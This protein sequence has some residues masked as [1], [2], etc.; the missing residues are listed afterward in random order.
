[1]LRLEVLGLVFTEINDDRNSNSESPVDIHFIGNNEDELNDMADII[2]QALI[3]DM[4]AFIT[5]ITFSWWL[6]LFKVFYKKYLF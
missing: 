6:S 3:Q 4:P 1:M 5:D 2:W